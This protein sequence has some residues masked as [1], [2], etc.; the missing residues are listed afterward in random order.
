ME[1]TTKAE[2]AS[3]HG[4]SLELTVQVVRSRSRGHRCVGVDSGALALPH[5]AA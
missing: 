5:C 2:Q 4:P 1:E 3:G